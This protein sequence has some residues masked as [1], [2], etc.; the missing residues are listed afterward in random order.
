MENKQYPIQLKGLMV[1]ELFIRVN[2]P[3]DSR[4]DE[5]REFSLGIGHSK[6]DHTNNSIEVIT[7]VSIGEPDNSEEELLSTPFDLKVRLIAKFI[8]DVNH[9][10]EDQI[11]PWAEHNAP[12][13][14][15]PYIREHV[16]SLTIRAGIGPVLL[17]LMQVPTLSIKQS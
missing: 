7:V 9:F 15:Y 13:I 12:I 4:T 17:P 3:Q 1:R 16:H 2:N 8:I 14:L 6:F 5:N 10:P 11:E